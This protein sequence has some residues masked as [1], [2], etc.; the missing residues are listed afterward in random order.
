MDDHATE[1]YGQRY[2]TWR[3]LD[4]LRYQTIQTAVGIFGVVAAI[5]QVNGGTPSA[6]LWIVLGAVMLI[7][8]KMLIK[9]NDAI[10][11]NGAVL[12]AFAKDVGD[13]SIPN[14]SDRKNSV[15]YWIEVVFLISGFCSIIWGII[16]VVLESAK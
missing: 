16:S 7:Q 4:S 8:W 1:R 14:V 11:A 10:V 5:L 3:H 15:F 6:W 2:E 12:A 13:L 9:V